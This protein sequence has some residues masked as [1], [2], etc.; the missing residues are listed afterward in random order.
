MG[1]A[2]VGGSKNIVFFFPAFAS[3]KATAPIGNVMDVCRRFPGVEFW[4]NIL[5]PYAGWPIMRRVKKPGVVVP[6]PSEGWANHLP[7]ATV[8]PWMMAYPA[9]WRLDR[10]LYALSFEL[11]L[12][13]AFEKFVSVAK[14]KVNSKQ[15]EPAVGVNC[16]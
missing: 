14:P 11:F 2:T 13:R 8:L 9:Q 3:S 7:R 1:E 12:N 6:G 15:L 16:P 5:T 10:Y 4:T